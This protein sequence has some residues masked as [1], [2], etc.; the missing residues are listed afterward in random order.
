MV[1]LAVLLHQRHPAASELSPG[2]TP[3]GQADHG[4]MID[5]I[6]GDF[7]VRGIPGCDN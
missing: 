2:G 4:V 3:L 1:K 7:Q 6:R 5:L